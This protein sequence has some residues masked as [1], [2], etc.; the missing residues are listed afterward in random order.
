MNQ[1]WVCPQGAES[2]LGQSEVTVITTQ[3]RGDKQMLCSLEE[4]GLYRGLPDKTLK[5]Q[6][7]LHVKDFT[8]GPVV[9]T[10]PSNAGGTG[11]IPGQDAKLLHATGCQ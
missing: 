11:S 4:R 3:D 10:L 9:K 8:G 5:A 2:P 7:N 1:I 6:L